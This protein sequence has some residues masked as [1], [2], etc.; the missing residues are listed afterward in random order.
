MCLYK[1]LVRPIL[2]LFDPENSHQLALKLSSFIRLPLIKHLVLAFTNVSSEKLKLKVFGIEFENPVGIAAGVDKNCEAL[3]VFKTFGFAWVEAGTI[4]PEPQQGNPRPRMHRFPNY[5]AIVNS[6]GFPSKGCVS[7]KAKLANYQDLP[8]IGINFG[9]NA[10]DEGDA[11]IKAYQTVAK[12]LEEFADFFVIN[13]SS[14]NTP[15]LRDFQEKNKLKPIIDAVKEV[16]IN[17]KPILVKLAP[18]LTIEQL[19]DAL[20]T[21]IETGVSGVVATNTTISRQEVAEAKDLPGGLSGQPLKKKS[22]DV[23]SHIYSF[24]NAKLPIIGVGGIASADDAIN[25]IKAGASLIGMYTG[26]VYEGPGLAKK[27]NQGILKHLS[28][29]KFESISDLI[30][31]K[32]K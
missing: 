8:V 21:C 10:K 25:M 26:L 14:P 16:N 27:I 7:A 9:K 13:V 32:H 22:L 11:V 5:S 12:S 19:N 23:V 28:M 18:D 20:S 1:N 6:M 2:F 4:T 30:G 17:N 24:T 31:S 15:G 3:D 29:N